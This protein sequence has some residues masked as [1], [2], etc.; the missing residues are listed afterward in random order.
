MAG[1]LFVHAHPDDE[2]ILT[3]G[4]IA[5]LREAN[6]PVTVLTA[7]RGEGGEVIGPL[8]D[9]LFGNRPALAQHREGELAE[10]MRVLG[11]EDWAF[12]G[13][14]AGGAGGKLPE[15][16]F[17]D[18]GMEWGPDGH[19]QPAAD[20][21]PES[22]CAAE[23]DEVAG[24]IAAVI[25]DRQPSLVVT[26]PKG[27]GY[28]HPDHVR[29]HD[30]TLRAVSMLKRR[31]R[32][33]VIYVDQPQPAVEKMFDV[34]RPGFDITGFE[35]AERVPTIPAEDPLVL[36]QDISA[37]R[38]AKAQAMAAHATQIQVAGD[39]YALSNNIGTVILAE[40]N[41]TAPGVRQAED[42][43]DYLD[44]AADA[45]DEAPGPVAAFVFSGILGLIVGVLGTFQ[46]LSASVI[47]LAGQAIILPWGLVFSLVFAALA[48][49]HTA[50]AYRSTSAVVFSGL[51]MSLVA[52]L[53]SQPALLPGQSLLVTGT[54]RSVAWLFGPM[55]L[56][57]IFSFTLPS[58][59]ANR[60]S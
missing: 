53:G 58:L 11:V 22:L 14:P 20:M 1:V 55:V 41:F 48:L 50:A 39:F 25:A 30:A 34:D 8:E 31:R 15:R 54:L 32:P 28:G 23:L 29:V 37:Q 33:R 35:P 45:E 51:I 38:G 4:T 40:E 47:D 5:R 19:A 56:A 59:R 10:A 60:K 17:E 21:P 46:H 42:I 24:Y 26:Y 6:V 57:A 12:L 13:T 49:W 16:R 36:T 44:P 43:L 2:S 52:F 3:G 9:S 7:T 27:G 18:S